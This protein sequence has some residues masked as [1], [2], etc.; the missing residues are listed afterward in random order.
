MPSALLLPV[1]I[2]NSW[3]TMRYGKFPMG[4]GAH[5]KFKVHQP[6]KISEFEDK[7]DLIKK[8]EDQITASIKI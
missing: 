1:T 4:I 7:I 6:I 8:V 5:I 3:K 2:N